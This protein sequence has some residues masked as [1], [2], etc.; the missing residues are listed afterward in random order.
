MY[1]AYIISVSLGK[2]VAGEMHVKAPVWKTSFLQSRLHRGPT[3]Q[4]EG[5]DIPESTDD[6]DLKISKEMNLSVRSRNSHNGGCPLTMG[7]FSQDPFPL[8]VIQLIW[9]EL[10]RA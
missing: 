1:L 7:Y 4:E 3:Q 9:V 8:K 6:S 2:V 5:T 10:L